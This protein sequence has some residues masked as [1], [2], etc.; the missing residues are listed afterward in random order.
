M[1][2]RMAFSTPAPTAEGTRPRTPGRATRLVGAARE[3][4]AETG[5]SAFTVQ[6]VVERAGL[7]LKSFYGHFSGKDDLLL[8]LLQEDSAVGSELL[9]AMVAMR[10]TPAERVE[11]WVTGLFHMLAVG[12]EGYV[13]VLVREHRRLAEA[14]PEQMAVA[15]APLLDLLTNL[16]DDAMRAGAI[17]PG[18]ARRDAGMIFDL[19]LS[20]MHRL[21]LDR[22]H[23][24]RGDRDAE[25][26]EVAAYV[27]RFCAAGLGSAAT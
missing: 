10:S 7:S 1:M 20:R 18:A 12:D 3:L 14:H 5:T 22:G 8:A 11:A 27:W 24:P 6:Q 19:V 9:A 16:L 17:R 13:G 2:G 23:D 4:A 15:L 21:V 26:D 25:A